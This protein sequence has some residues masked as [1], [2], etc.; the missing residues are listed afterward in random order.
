MDAFSDIPNEITEHILASLTAQD[1][2]A[3]SAVSLYISNYLKLHFYGHIYYP[4]SPINRLVLPS[5]EKS[6]GPLVTTTDDS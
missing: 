4:I 5:N 3:F 2:L 1:I 6:S